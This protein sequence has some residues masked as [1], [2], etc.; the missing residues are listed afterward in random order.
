MGY[1]R[2]RGSP[3]L[4]SCRFKDLSLHRVGGRGRIRVYLVP[5]PCARLRYAR[6]T[7]VSA[8]ILHARRTHFLSFPWRAASDLSPIPPCRDVPTA[9]VGFDCQYGTNPFRVICPGHLHRRGR[10]RGRSRIRPRGSFSRQGGAKEETCV[11]FRT[12][13]NVFVILLYYYY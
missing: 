8:A 4:H 2:P 13:R 12:T 9:H 1:L 10:G 5:R 6:P 3:A 11:G 7:R